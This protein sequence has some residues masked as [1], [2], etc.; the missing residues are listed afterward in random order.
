[1]KKI[2]FLLSM[3]LATYT[4]ALTLTACSGEDD[5]KEEK[6]TPNTPTNEDPKN[7]DGPTANEL[8]VMTSCTPCNGGG[9]CPTC[10]GS[11]KGCEA[12]GGSGNCKA[13]GGNGKC[14]GCGGSGNCRKCDGSKKCKNCTDGK[15]TCNSCNGYKKCKNC[16]GTGSI[17]GTLWGQTSTCPICNGTTWCRECDGTG[18]IDCKYC[19]KGQCDL[20]HGTGKHDTCDGTGDC[21]LCGGKRTCKTC[22]GDGGHCSQCNSDGKCKTC[23]GTGEVTLSS[24][25]FSNEGGSERFQIHSNGS[26]NAS[27]DADWIKLSSPSGSGNSSF[28]ITADAN[29]T[30]STRS[31]KVTFSYNGK[32]LTISVTQSGGTAVSGTFEINGIYYNLTAG[33]I[34]AEVTSKSSGKYSGA[35]AIP[36]TVEYGGVT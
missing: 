12:C 14:I 23:S 10:K 30:T 29:K 19:Y 5:R 4:V 34:Q 8:T 15:V 27:T 2:L 21:D 28:T 26:W 20:C 11:G 17:S 24:V 13:C 32:S 25:T 36:N 6:Q 31:D 9:K 3:V 18:K 33:T 22:G 35:I 16:N 1:M 7:N